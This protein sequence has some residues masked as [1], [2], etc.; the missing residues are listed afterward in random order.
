MFAEF[1]EAGLRCELITEYAKE[2]AWDKRPIKKYDQI[3]IVSEQIFRESRLYGQVDYIISDSPAPLGCFYEE[4]FYPG[5]EMV[6]PMMRRFLDV[7]Q[8]DS[9]QIHYYLPYIGISDSSGRYHDSDQSR[10]IDRRLLPWLAEF[11]I[12]P[13]IWA[14]RYISDYLAQEKA[15]P[16]NCTEAA[17]TVLTIKKTVSSKGYEKQGSFFG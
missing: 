3:K 7:R 2:W 1:K 4:Y 14:D 15:R 9:E 16:L 17:F 6:R 5:Q 11:S 13:Q 10:D 12:V 8:Q